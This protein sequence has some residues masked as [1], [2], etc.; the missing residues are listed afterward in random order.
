MMECDEFISLIE[1]F[2][3][4]DKTMDTVK[5]IEFKVHSENCEECRKKYESRV[6]ERR[7]EERGY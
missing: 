3:N 1:D 5:R 2:I 6:E 7:I 4:Q